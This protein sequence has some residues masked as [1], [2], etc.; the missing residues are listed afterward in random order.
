[1]AS[2]SQGLDW[3]YRS[4]SAVNGV[5]YTDKSSPEAYAESYVKFKL[6]RSKPEEAQYALRNWE[7]TLK[8]A[9]HLC[10]ANDG[11]SPNAK[12]YSKFLEFSNNI[13][14]NKLE[15]KDNQQLF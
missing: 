6:W 7:E 14:I 11:L 2:K 8:F 13:D 5:G 1:M 3:L 4:M 15:F 10:N 12:N 9:E